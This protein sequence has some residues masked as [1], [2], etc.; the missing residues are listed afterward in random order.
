MKTMI[1]TE[2]S[3]ISAISRLIRSI[4]T[5]APVTTIRDDKACMTAGPISMRTEAR[6]LVARESRSPVRCS[7]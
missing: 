7:W 4:I 2:V 5:K 3:D 1:G 6:S